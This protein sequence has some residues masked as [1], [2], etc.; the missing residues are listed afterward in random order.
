[1]TFGEY[2][3]VRERLLE[4][5]PEVESQVGRYNW[6]S[7]PRTLAGLVAAGVF[8]LCCQPRFCGELGCLFWSLIFVLNLPSKFHYLS[9]LVYISAPILDNQTHIMNTTSVLRIAGRA[10][11]PT[12][13]RLLQRRWNSSPAGPGPQKE[14]SPHVS[15]IGHLEGFILMN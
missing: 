2:V 12:T 10:R 3:M 9:L 13:S 1:M 7:V 4:T 8:A 15:S 11:L 6:K 5:Y 14:V